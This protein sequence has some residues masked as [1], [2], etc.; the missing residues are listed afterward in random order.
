MENINL[1]EVLFLDAETTGLPPKN[2]KWD[3]DF[4]QFPYIV[5]LSWFFNGVEKDYIIYPEKWEIPVASVEIHGITTEQAQKEGVMLCDVLAEFISDCEKAKLLIGH[6]IYFDIST[7]KA[8][9]LRCDKGS[10]NTKTDA[11]LF[12]G[13]RIDTMRKSLKFVGATMP[14]SKRLKYPTLEEL[15]FHLFHENFPAH[16]SME[17]VRALV[18]CVPELVAAG[19]IELKQKEY[20]DETKLEPTVEENKGGNTERIAGKV[21]EAAITLPLPGSREVNEHS[22]PSSQANAELLNMNDF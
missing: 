12:K 1:S 6:N 22:A 10:Y 13:K 11:A 5:S 2:A 16:N 18:R 7:I 3:E 19:V 8:N 14:N 21:M 9:I 4:D 15:Y 17:D 20:P